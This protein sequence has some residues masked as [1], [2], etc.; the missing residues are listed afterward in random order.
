MGPDRFKGS[1]RGL[2]RSYQGFRECNS[3]M[4]GGCAG[5]DKARREVSDE[6]NRAHRSHAIGTECAA[7]FQQHFIAFMMCNCRGAGHA[8]KSP[9]PQ[10]VQA[11]TMMNRDYLDS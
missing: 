1:G 10:L 5:E 6:A 7:T 2:S 3:S 11:G 4:D 8:D 9:D